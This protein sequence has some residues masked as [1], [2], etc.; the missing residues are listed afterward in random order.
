MQSAQVI[1]LLL[2]DQDTESA[3][4]HRAENYIAHGSTVLVRSADGR[5][6]LE[7]VTADTEFMEQI[8]TTGR[9]RRGKA[10]IDPM[11]RQVMGYEMEMITDPPRRSPF[12]L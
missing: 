11:T 7:T 3:A 6:L 9:F 5:M 1:A 10:I 8:M 4:M 12:A 2:P